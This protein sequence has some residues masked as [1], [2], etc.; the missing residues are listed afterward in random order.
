[1]NDLPYPS[2]AAKLRQTLETSGGSVTRALIRPKLIGAACALTAAVIWGGMYVVSKV[3]LDVIPPLSLVAARF[4]LCSLVLFAAMRLSRAMPIARRDWPMVARIGIVGFGLSVVLQFVGTKLTSAANG[5]LVTSAAPAFIV[6]F[7]ALL[8]REALTAR[9]LIGLALATGG[10]VVVIAPTDLSASLP[11]NL[12]LL[13]AALTWGLYSVLVRSA[14]QTYPTLSVS[15]YAGL[16]GG[17][18]TALLAPLELAANPLGVVTPAI[19]LGVLYLAFIATALAMVLW[20][21]ALEILGAGVTAI[22][23]FAQ[24]VAGAL[25]GWLLLGESLGPNFFLGGAL[26]LLAVA[27]TAGDD[28]AGRL[29]LQ[30]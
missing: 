18:F 21:K 16:A 22:F 20:N 30:R 12:A 27:L 7:A 24:P 29:T 28:G 9:K 26:I 11:G 8:L 25:L 15:A 4:L 5:A 6:L 13:A 23:F 3:V 14:V 2:S 10:V 1:M 17:L 19:V